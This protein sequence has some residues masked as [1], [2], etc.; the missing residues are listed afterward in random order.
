METPP[1]SLCRFRHLRFKPVLALVWRS[2]PWLTLINA[3][4]LALQAVLPLLQIYLL[5]LTVD[6][7]AATLAAP[8]PLLS[9]RWVMGL[10]GLTAAAAM[11]SDVVSSAIKIIAHAQAEAVSDRVQELLHAKSAELDLG[12]YESVPFHDTF[13]RA[14]QEAP[15]RPLRMVTNFFQVAQNG[16]IAVGILGL[17]IAFHWGIAVALGAA[18]APGLL[19]RLKYSRQT[20]QWQLA[21]SESERTAIYLNNLITGESHAKELRLF[22]L[23]PMLIDRCRRLR[24]QMRMERTGMA[25]RQAAAEAAAQGIAVAAVYGAFAYIAYRSVQGAM[26]LGD[27]VMYY[28][29]FQRGQGCLREV[30]H[31][32]ASLIEDNLFLSSFYQFLELRPL[33]TVSSS[34]APVP[35]PLREGIAFEKV[36]FSYPQSERLVMSEVSLHVRPGQV[37][38]L[39]GEN[40]AGKTTLVKLL[41]RFYDP[42]SGN[43][44]LDGVDLRNFDCLEL[45]SKIGIIFQDYSR[46]WM[47]VRENI[48]IGDVTLPL[49]D[50]R[51]TAAAVRAGAHKFIAGLPAGYNTLLGR[52]FGS[53]AELSIGEWQQLAL[54]RAFLRDSPILVLD[55]PTSAL[56]ARNER[57][58]FK[59]FKRL[60]A[61]RTAILISHHFSTTKMADRIFVLADGR[62]SEAG[63]HAELL[64]TGGLY[65]RLYKMQAHAYRQ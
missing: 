6:A 30:F 50:P 51:I 56:D 12:Y 58:V 37:V 48:R 10:I 34:P 11:S 7:V 25:L 46:Y 9:L 1:S 53:G 43:I 52:G 14:Q 15:Y 35:E 62:I 49:G 60:A 44:T 13:H 33:I 54:A 65:A 19:V 45:R 32:L 63:T 39:V 61:G 26:T 40:G 31:G 27:L 23:G 8:E 42:L 4:A 22:N 24:R 3:L 2:A 16:V 41:C 5:K 28:Q 57:I 18:L 20:Y 59:H 21:K 17:L 47:T 36:S 29:G 64:E 38:A 55:E